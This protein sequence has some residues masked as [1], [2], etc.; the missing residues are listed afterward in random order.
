MTYIG[1]EVASKAEF[2]EICV[3]ELK[4]KITMHLLQVTLDNKLTYA[5]SRIHIPFTSNKTLGS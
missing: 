1:T 4:H 3:I 2:I 5:R